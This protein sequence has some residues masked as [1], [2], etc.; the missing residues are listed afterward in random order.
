MQLRGAV[1]RL[2]LIKGFAD[3]AQTG[4]PKQASPGWIWIWLGV[5]FLPS[6]TI[7][8]VSHLVYVF[9]EELPM[10]K[11]RAI[12]VLHTLAALDESG[13]RVSLIYQRGATAESPFASC[14][15]PDPPGVILEPLPGTL[16]GT[17]WR[18]GWVF[19]QR[20]KGRLREKERL[21]DRPD[22]VMVRHIKL[23][24][25]L[26]TSNITAP[27]I[28]EAHEVFA[29]TVRPHRRGTMTRSEQ[30]VL[31]RSSAKIAITRRLAELLT[32]RYGL[33]GSF[34]ILP[35]GADLPAEPPAKDWSQ[36]HRSIVYTGSL[37]EWKGVDDLVKAASLLD[38]DVVVTIIGGDAPEVLRLQQASR[39]H[40]QGA[41][42][43]YL[44][45]RTH[46][47]V[48]KHLKRACLAILPNRAGSISEFTSP[49]K[50]FEY[51][52]HGC[53]IVAS[54]LPVFRE[55]L[56]PAD[57][58]WHKPGDPAS[59]AAAIRNFL[60][61]PASARAAASSAHALAGQYTW[62][63]RAESLG[64]IIRQLRQPTPSVGGGR[65]L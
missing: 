57:A 30:F 7:S 63:A 48:R 40:N 36:C 2:L 50:L 10:P 13:V 54:D 20:V 65:Q 38:Q 1:K 58:A 34:H 25:R 8:H 62:K 31:E 43:D 47:E 56:G 14:G 35:S 64:E 53:A 3:S 52:A 44:G 42:I 32:A 12:Q 55:V 11:A 61:N 28:Y 27:L 4:K 26:L 29:D 24:H 21:G 17:A 39:H 45:R 37:Y 6:M 22:A 19:A 46:Q 33:P 23:A 51:M 16:P 41:R 9:P 60:Q 5:L 15:L 18:S 59:L 49:I